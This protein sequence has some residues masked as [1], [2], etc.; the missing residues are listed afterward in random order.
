MDKL[1]LIVVLILASGIVGGVGNFFRFESNLEA[2]G[3]HLV[4]SIF[5]GTIAAFTIPLFLNMVSSDLLEFQNAPTDYFVFVGF[6]LIAAFFSNRFMNS[7][8]DRVIQDL[9]KIKRKTDVIE[10]ET[11]DNSEKVEAL[12]E[13]QTDGG[14]TAAKPRKLEEI[15]NEVPAEVANKIFESFQNEKYKFRTVE[16]I[17]KDSGLDSGET[18]ALMDKLEQKNIIK[19]YR[20]RGGKRIY[21]LTD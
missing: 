14:T 15:K 20:G 10:E 19:R 3:Y 6:C 4:K 1:T 16:G 21:S 18:K 5:L 7:I 12:V 9:E 2:K 8:G 11:K 13:E 17:A